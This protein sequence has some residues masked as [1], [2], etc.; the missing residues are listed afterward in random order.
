MVTT[1]GLYTVVALS[2]AG[3]LAFGAIAARTVFLIVTGK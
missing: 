3:W 2:I 1:A